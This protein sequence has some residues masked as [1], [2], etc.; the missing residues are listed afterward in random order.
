MQWV[1]SIDAFS[2]CVRKRCLYMTKPC[3]IKSGTDGGEEDAGARRRGG[4]ATCPSDERRYDSPGPGR[5][6]GLQQDR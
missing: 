6:R 5:A 1:E 3:V 4:H 2:G